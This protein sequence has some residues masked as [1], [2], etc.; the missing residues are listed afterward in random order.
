M[1]LGAG[2]RGA[3]NPAPP[4]NGSPPPTASGNTPPPSATPPPPTRRCAA[5]PCS[6][7][8]PATPRAPGSSSPAP[9][10]RPPPRP[11]AFSILWRVREAHGRE[12]VTPLLP[13]LTRRL[14]ELHAAG[15][16]ASP[17]L[18]ALARLAL[19]S[20]GP[21]AAAGLLEKGLAL[22]DR[23]DITDAVDVRVDLARYYA[24][25]GRWQDATAQLLDAATRE[26]APERKAMLQF[27]AGDAQERAGA[28]EAAFEHYLAASRGG[29]HPHKA[30]TA[31]D[32]I[33]SAIGTVEQRVEVLQL[34]IHQGDTDERVRSLRALAEL[35]RGPLGKPERAAGLLRELLKLRPANTDVILELYELLTSLGREEE[36][37]VALQAGIAAQRAI[38]RDRGL[39]STGEST[40]DPLDPDPVLGLLR[41]FDAAEE[42]G[43]VY[44]CAAI[45]EAIDPD[46]VPTHRRCDTVKPDPWPLPSPARSARPLLRRRRPRRR[47][48]ARPAAHR[49]P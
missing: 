48:R 13:A 6:P 14:D 23:P 36:G 49:R 9:S 33:A 3:A 29:Y 35:F 27:L 20:D 15:R 12:G 2:R 32:R 10:T 26:P 44:V 34:L 43:G 47:R 22:T 16:L 45:L 24:R 46:L 11:L 31:A 21:A 30:L 5:P 18:R 37:R 28:P 39:S 40:S 17:D 7:S 25:V 8:R 41:L 38:L 42:P 4:P 1:S 19:D